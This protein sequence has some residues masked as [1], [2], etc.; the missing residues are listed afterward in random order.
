MHTATRMLFLLLFSA[1]VLAGPIYRCTDAAGVLR[2]TDRACPGRGEQLEESALQPNVMTSAA[3]PADY[4]SSDEYERSSET[5]SRK[6][7]GCNNAADLRHIDLMLK[8]LTSDKRQRRFLKAERKRVVNC[9]LN[10]LPASERRQRDAAL[11][12]TRSLRES[13]RETAETE[14]EGLY[15]AQR[16]ARRPRKR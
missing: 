15:A 1:N 14:I 4:G 3:V 9:E 11:R 8:S 6:Q 12:R 2:F 13:E 7:G 16:P 5:A 10:N